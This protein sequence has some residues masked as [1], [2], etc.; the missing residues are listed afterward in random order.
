MS[1]RALPASVTFYLLLSKVR[2]C[3]SSQKEL[4]AEECRF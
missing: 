3:D 2:I 4:Q 1:G